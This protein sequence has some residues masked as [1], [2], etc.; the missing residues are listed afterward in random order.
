VV[1]DNSKTIV[2]KI[3]G[4][5]GGCDVGGPRRSGAAAGVIGLMLVL[6]LARG[7]RRSA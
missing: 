1:A 6:G 7:R 2:T 4:S 3:G 5:S